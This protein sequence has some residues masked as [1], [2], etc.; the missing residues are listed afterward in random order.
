MRETILLGVDL[1]FNLLAWRIS[2]VYYL[3]PP[4]DGP[5]ADGSVGLAHS[6]D[7]VVRR[8]VDSNPLLPGS[9]V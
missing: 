3:C 5:S 8:L 7:R 6:L 4:K 2:P 1:I 9:E